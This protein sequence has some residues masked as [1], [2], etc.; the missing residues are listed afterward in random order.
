MALLFIVSLTS[1]VNFLEESEFLYDE[2]DKS[3][4]VYFQ[5]FF[6]LLC[7]LLLDFLYLLSSNESDSLDDESDYD[8]SDY[9]Y[10]GICAFP[11]RLD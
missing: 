7:P 6:F 5:C 2:S 8:G 10:S 1:I 3:C 11:L 9:R 4:F